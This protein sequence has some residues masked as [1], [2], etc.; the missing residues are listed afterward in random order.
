[1][2][3]GP[4][5]K[6]APGRLAGIAK[7]AILVAATVACYLPA[8]GADFIWD[9][10]VYVDWQTTRD[11][12]DGLRRIWFEPGSTMQYY[13]VA[14]SVFWLQRRMWDLEPFGYHLVN[15]LL[16]AANAILL[17]RLL[18]RLGVGGAFIAAAIF[19]IHPVCVE[20]VAWVCEL[21]NTL[22]GLFYL[23]AGLAY[24]R[25]SPP[26][27][28]GP[29]AD[30]WPWYAAAAMLFILAVLT[31]TVTASWPAAV[32]LV[33]WW[34]RGRFNWRDLCVMIPLFLAGAG[35]G[36]LTAWM[37]VYHAGAGGGDWALG[38]GE[39]IIL[40]GRALWFYAGKLAWPAE[41]V[42]IYPRWNL[43][44]GDR[45]QWL[46]TISAILVIG[47]LWLF[48]RRAGRGP[49][50]GVLFFAGTLFPALGFF[51]VYP[52][53]FSFVADH[54][55]YLASI[56][57][58]ALASSA[59]WRL[60]VSRPSWPRVP[61]ASRL[62]EAREQMTNCEGKMPSPHAGETPAT[63]FQPFARRAVVAC[64]IGL[65]GVLCVLTCRHCRIFHDSET[66]WTDTLAK[67][68]RCWLAGSG[69][70]DAAEKAGN[71]ERAAQFYERSLSL[72][73]NQPQTIFNLGTDLIKMG[74]FDGAEEQFVRLAA[75]EPDNARVRMNLGIVL[76]QRGRV[77]DG[78]ANL[79]KAAEL[80]PQS[81]VIRINLGRALVEAGRYEQAIEQI[82][83]AVKV[84]P[85]SET[86][87]YCLGLAYEKAGRT[88]MA[89]SC[90]KRCLGINPSNRSASEALRRL[91]RPAGQASMP[92]SLAETSPAK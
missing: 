60:Y 75:M 30:R 43:D 41:L 38:W 21:K 52:F 15:V 16:H 77:D 85:H 24:L 13:P 32:L 47:S 45:L 59:A 67:N 69:L 89:G 91:L 81:A 37:E 10:D 46:W 48:R 35:A 78:I 39:R 23:L 56:G 64:V 57:L 1:M 71:F 76:M 12:R 22:S 63:H 80:Q 17:W 87:W 92:A 33:L 73:P 28:A 36:L 3:A 40:A 34:K 49:L 42:F 6:P 2:N 79:R 90:Y 65:A 50:T 4:D 26:Q 44:A 25:F 74:R 14:Y 66:L 58:I 70:G 19:A 8:L 82:E 5:I 54:F 27:R 31:K 72:Y 20:S 55:Q 86:G 84:Q 11:S 68:D 83:Q 88:G 62:R 51:N 9:D 53:R 61:Q 18:S 7:G 29:S